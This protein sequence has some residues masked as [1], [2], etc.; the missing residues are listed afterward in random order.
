MPITVNQGWAQT[1]ASLGSE[2]EVKDAAKGGWLYYTAGPGEAVA[3]P[4]AKQA[5]CNTCHAEHG[6]VDHTFVQ[7]YPSLVDAAKRHG[8]LRSPTQ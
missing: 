8:T 2:L 6:A 4:V 3:K 1:G 5:D 7:F